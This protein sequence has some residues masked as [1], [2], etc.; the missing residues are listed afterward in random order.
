MRNTIFT[1][2]LLTAMKYMAYAQMDGSGSFL[3][4]DVPVSAM[5]TGIGGINVSRADADVNLLTS[6]PALVSDALDGYL[7]LNYVIY[8]G[9]IKVSNVSY[10][11]SFANTGN[12]SANLVYFDYGEIN[13]FDDTGTS[14]GTFRADEYAI[15]IGKSH[16]AGNYRLAVNA[17]YAASTIA[18][19][20]ASSLLFDLGGIFIHPEKDFNAGL[21]IKNAGIVL[22]KFTATNNIALPFN[23]QVGTSFKPAH[24]PVR[25]SL[26]IYDLTD[27]AKTDEQ[28]SLV[29]YEQ[30]TTIDRFFR[31]TIFGMEVL[32]G[33]HLRLLA[34]YD[35][36]KRRELKLINVSGSTGFSYG[37][38]VSVKS[39]EFGFSR[40]TYHVAGASNTFT[41]T[42]DLKNL[43][44]KKTTVE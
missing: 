40:A 28:A 25:F 26:S 34:G 44:M 23:V 37:L 22:N 20:T 7:S 17:K 19:Y 24:M 27:W 10:S 4:L 36:K 8:P 13:S 41:L 2:T 9:D 6:N 5:L 30:P 32:A 3:F 16:Q 11:Q 33:K 15:T 35:H 18:G 29:D 38:M 43:I 31:H 14:V 39:F 42:S 21:V 12:W 1:L